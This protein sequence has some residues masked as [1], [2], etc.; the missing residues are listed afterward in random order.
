[1]KV[2]KKDEERIGV[3]MRDSEKKGKKEGG[4]CWALRTTKAN[5]AGKPWLNKRFQ[6]KFGDLC[7]SVEVCNWF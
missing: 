7:N 4:C 5:G 2:K 1:M 6:Y 3:R